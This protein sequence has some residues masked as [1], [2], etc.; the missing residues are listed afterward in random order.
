MAGE[1]T[2]WS[3]SKYFGDRHRELIDEKLARYRTRADDPRIVLVDRVDQLEGDL[4]RALL[5]LQALA[6]TCVSKGVFSCQEIA[7]MAKTIDA[8][9]GIADGK[10]DPQTMRPAAPPTAEAVS[11]EEH[12]RRLEAESR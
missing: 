4:G 10:L 5:M 8:L 2:M 6:E 11:P 1:W 3:I 9:D 12:L 7:D